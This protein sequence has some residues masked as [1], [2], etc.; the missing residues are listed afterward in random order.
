M[1]SAVARFPKRVLKVGATDQEW[2]EKI[3]QL[4]IQMKIVLK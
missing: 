1:V 2:F 4:S 3:I